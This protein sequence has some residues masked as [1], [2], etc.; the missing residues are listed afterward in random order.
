MQPGDPVWLP[1][2]N[3]G[4]DLR[5]L[6]YK[7]LCPDLPP[8]RAALSFG[9]RAGSISWYLTDDISYPTMAGFSDLNMVAETMFT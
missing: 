4:M 2:W 5:H 6:E 9:A 8:R 7:N 1:C 3:Q